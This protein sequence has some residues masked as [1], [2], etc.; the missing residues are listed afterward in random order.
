MKAFKYRAEIYLHLSDLRLRTE[1]EFRLTDQKAGI[2]Y[3]DLTRFHNKP[4]IVV[5]DNYDF[6]KCLRKDIL[7]IFV[8]DENKNSSFF[9]TVK[10][11]VKSITKTLNHAL[12]FLSINAL[13]VEAA[14]S[15]NDK[16]NLIK[17][18]DNHLN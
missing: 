2:F 6:A 7:K 13:N 12:V 14:A 18:C 10:P 1:T 5:T 15:A 11:E 16:S 9:A 17:L 8:S 4:H 3:C